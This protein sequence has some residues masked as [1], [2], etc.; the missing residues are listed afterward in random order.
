MET[1]R[2]WRTRPTTASSHLVMHYQ[3]NDYKRKTQI[4]TG[5]HPMGKWDAETRAYL[6][7]T[8][9]TLFR[10]NLWITNKWSST[11]LG[12]PKVRATRTDYTKLFCCFNLVMNTVTNQNHWTNCWETGPLLNRHYQLC[13][14]HGLGRDHNK[15]MCVLVSKTYQLLSQRGFHSRS[16]EQ[17]ETRLWIPAMR[18]SRDCMK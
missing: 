4:S 8:F 1:T 17:R 9:F 18:S 5:M 10:S 11:T 15:C 16:W 12:S 2:G 14:Q 3:M 13:C 7:L 6:S